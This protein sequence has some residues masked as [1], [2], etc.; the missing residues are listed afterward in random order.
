MP[1]LL[2]KKTIE[3][4]DCHDFVRR[5]TKLWFEV[6]LRS[7]NLITISTRYLLHHVGLVVHDRET[8]VGM[9]PTWSS[10]S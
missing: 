8:L 3:I 2:N 9:V 1:D 5:F 10:P 7:A 6:D 4:F